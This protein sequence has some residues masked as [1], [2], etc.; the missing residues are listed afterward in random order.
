MKPPRKPC[1][2]G[3]KARIATSFPCILQQQGLQA[4]FHVWCRIPGVAPSTPSQPPAS[5]LQPISCRPEKRQPAR[6]IIDKPRAY[7]GP[8]CLV[9]SRN[10]STWHLGVFSFFL[11]V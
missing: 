2:V 4:T 1:P 9:F 10:I 11:A 3:P 7:T 5:S 6:S 8:P